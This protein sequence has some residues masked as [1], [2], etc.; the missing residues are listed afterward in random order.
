MHKICEPSRRPTHSRPRALHTLLVSMGIALCSAPALSSQ[1]NLSWQRVGPPE[2]SNRHS[3]TT[4]PTQGGGGVVVFTTTGQTWVY[5]GQ[6][7][8]QKQTSIAPLPREN[9]SMAWDATNDIV[10]LFGGATTGALLND[11]WT[12]DGSVWTSRP[13]P[14]PLVARQEHAMAYDFSTNQIILFGGLDAAGRRRGDTWAWTPAGWTNLSPAI[15]PSA[16][17]LHAMASE[18]Q[19][20]GGVMLF[21]G[22]DGSNPNDTWT[23]RA[24]TWRQETPVVNPPGD[25]EHAMEA[26]YVR[27]EILLTGGRNHRDTAWIWTGSNWSVAPPAPSAG[28]RWAEMGFDG[29]RRVIVSFGGLLNNGSAINSVNEW[30]GVS[31]SAPEIA[32]IA[33]RYHSMSFDPTSGHTWIDGGLD[34]SGR[35]IN[36]TWSFDG[37]T[38]RLE[39][40]Q[41]GGARYLASME[42]DPVSGDLLLIGGYTT[43]ST[44]TTFR[45]D[46]AARGWSQLTPPATFAPTRHDH[47][48]V[49]VPGNTRRGV[50]VFGGSNGNTDLGDLWHWNGSSWQQLNTIGTPP[51]PRRAAGF[52]LEPGGTSALLFGGADRAQLFNDTWR[53]DLATLSWTQLFPTNP[54]PAQRAHSLVTDDVRSVLHLAEDGTNVVWTWDPNSD[55]WTSSGTR[56]ESRLELRMAPAPDNRILAFGGSVNGQGVFDTGWALTPPS[57]GTFTPRGTSCGPSTGATPSLV[58]TALP[59]INCP[60]TLELRNLPLAGASA[61]LFLDAAPFASP[62]PIPGCAGC[63]LRI[64]GDV[65]IPLRVVFGTAILTSNIPDVPALIGSR[66]R[67]QGAVFHSSFPCLPGVG[68][69]LSNAG[70]L[71][72]G[73]D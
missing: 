50:L 37:S 27:G 38:W 9:A 23:F 42:H 57:P 14:A 35:Q 71:L 16:R 21:S 52:A 10:V 69:G 40:R 46:R 6:A 59:H 65:V 39:T 70:D 48:S 55:A 47:S 11:T 63:T 64:R 54:P 31:W 13:T 25:Y 44:D 20:G 5:D 18:L 43:R 72:V 22:S 36:D 15:A 19:S 17:F 41:A 29:N 26:D 12:W 34:G 8:E 62:L 68:L 30:D 24:G 4:N 32:P 28:S 33:R 1:C 7:W 66:L 58:C 2:R 53:L 56:S 45:W 61:A 3:M 49:R 67:A 51:S 73:V 60:F